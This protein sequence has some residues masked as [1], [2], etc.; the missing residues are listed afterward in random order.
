[1]T[2]YYRPEDAS[3]DLRQ[4]A[5][6]NV[7]FCGTNTGQDVPET[8]ASGDNHW[9]EVFGAAALGTLLNVG[10][11]TSEDPRLAYGGIGLITRD[12]VDAAVADGVQRSASAIAIVSPRSMV[13]PDCRRRSV[14][15][16]ARCPSRT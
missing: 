12:P 15:A 10:V 6:G 1:M 9:G 13:L 14:M 8:E 3:V 5:L 2:S 16:C 7:R 4:L 11:A